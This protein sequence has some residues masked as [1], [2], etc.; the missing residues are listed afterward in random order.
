MKRIF[1]VATMGLLIANSGL[2]QTSSMGGFRKNF[3]TVMFAGLGGAILG[4]ST[5]SFYGNPQEHIGNI[6]TGLTIGGLAGVGYVISNVSESQRASDAYSSLENPRE[7]QA[8]KP[9]PIYLP[10]VAM[11]F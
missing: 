10:L 9:T 7:K 2:A 8:R 4:L 6:W 5:L 3:A 1:L 11:D